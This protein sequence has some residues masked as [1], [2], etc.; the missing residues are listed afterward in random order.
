MSRHQWH[1]DVI[2][3]MNCLERERPKMEACDRLITAIGLV[4]N[5]CVRD[6]KIVESA[7]EWATE[8]LEIYQTLYLSKTREDLIHGNLIL[9]SLELFKS[10]KKLS[11]PDGN[12]ASSVI[13]RSADPILD[14]Y[15]TKVSQTWVFF[16]SNFANG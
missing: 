3:F 15:K 11:D 8:F 5:A 4:R 10:E 6:R 1:T 7:Q 2:G 14:S 16:T 13:L 9:E 12:T